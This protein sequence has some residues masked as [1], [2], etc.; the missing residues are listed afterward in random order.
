[1]AE[2]VFN[3]GLQ[4]QRWNHRVLRFVLDFPHHL[5][6]VGEAHQLDRQILLY[7]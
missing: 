2:R 3:E 4:Q 6:P 7:Q 1:M 5:K